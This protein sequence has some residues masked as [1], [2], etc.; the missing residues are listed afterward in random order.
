MSKESI[1]IGED[2]NPD[3][4]KNVEPDTEVKKMVGRIRG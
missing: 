2:E 1:L 4:F 3:L